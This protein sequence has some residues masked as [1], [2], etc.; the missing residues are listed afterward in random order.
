MDLTHAC[1][2]TGEWNGE[3]VEG[4]VVRTRIIEPPTSRKGKG[5]NIAISPY[6][7]GSS[8]FFKVR[9]VEP[10][11][12]Y[13]D[14]REI[15]ESLLSTK[16][17]M[18]PSVLPKSKMGRAETKLYV[19]WVIEEIIKDRASFKEYTQGKGIIATREKFLKFLRTEE[20]VKELERFNGQ[21]GLEKVEETL[22]VMNGYDE[23]AVKIPKNLKK[24]KKFDPRYYALLPEVD[25][26]DLLD[27]R[28]AEE[29]KET[30]DFWAKL[31]KDN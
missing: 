5:K 27:R 1:A 31:K 10:Y 7:V 8:F 26:E 15:T 16:N 9:Y 13:R 6:N 22:D 25:L 18:T 24:R 30:R 14:W 28:F 29:T 17:P 20:G 19:K 23:P 2:E 11:K 21:E 3:A 4:F 12:M